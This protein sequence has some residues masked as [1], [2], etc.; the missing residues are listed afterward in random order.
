MIIVLNGRLTLISKIKKVGL[1]KGALKMSL[2]LSYELK[3][4]IVK[5]LRD[6]GNR[7]RFCQRMRRET[8]VRK[9][10]L[11]VQSLQTESERFL[12]VLIV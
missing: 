4:F 2:K 8:N 6:G 1:D 7:R 9:G 5:D 12:E 10:K 3:N 11:L